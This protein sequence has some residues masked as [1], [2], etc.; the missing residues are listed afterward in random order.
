VFQLVGHRL[1]DR[2]GAMTGLVGAAGGVGGFL[3]PFGFGSLVSTTGT[4][5]AGFAVLAAVAN[6]AALAVVS[7]ERTWTLQTLRLSLEAAR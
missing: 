5:A 7:R 4:F 1:P 6:L 3:L 2:V